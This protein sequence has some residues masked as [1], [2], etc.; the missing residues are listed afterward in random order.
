MTHNGDHTVGLEKGVEILQELQSEEG[1]RLGST[2]KDIVNDVVELAV[3]RVDKQVGISDR[4]SNDWCV[5]G[6]QL[7]VLGREFMHNGIDLDHRGF[8][9]MCNKSGRRR[10]NTKASVILD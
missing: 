9:T 1:N 8:D 7:K 4:I 10:S 6:R 2:S 5:V 3:C